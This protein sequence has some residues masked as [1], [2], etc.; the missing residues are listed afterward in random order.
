MRSRR[1]NDAKLLLALNR[2]SMMPISDDGVAVLTRTLGHHTRKRAACHRISCLQD[3][4]L[5]TVQS[6]FGWRD[7]PSREFGSPLVIRFAQ[8]LRTRHQG[9]GFVALTGCRVRARQ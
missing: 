9:H 8:F 5:G 2:V 7:R 4:G 3:L 6:L 1:D